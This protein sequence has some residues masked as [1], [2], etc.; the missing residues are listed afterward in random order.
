MALVRFDWAAGTVTV[1][2]VGNVEI[3]V[4]DTTERLSF[5]VRRGFLGRKAPRPAVRTTAWPPQARMV[6]HTDGIRSTDLG[7]TYRELSDSEPRALARML[8]QRLARDRDDATVAVLARRD[9]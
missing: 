4:F 9:E 8:L 6:L 3:R 2:N 7:E 5:V 1:G